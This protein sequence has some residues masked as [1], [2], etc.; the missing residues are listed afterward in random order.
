MRTKLIVMRK[1]H[2]KPAL[3]VWRNSEER[4]VE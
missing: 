2:G 1:N 4:G 3:L